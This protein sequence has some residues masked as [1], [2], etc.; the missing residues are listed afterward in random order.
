MPSQSLGTLSLNI[1]ANVSQFNR[2][3]TQANSQLRTFSQNVKGMGR[4]AGLKGMR[5]QMGKTSKSWGSGMKSMQGVTGVAM[6]NIVAMIAQKGMQMIT[7]AFKFIIN[8]FKEYESA[9]TNAAAVSGVYGAAI[10]TVKESMS[11]F[12]KTLS[13]KSIYTMNE[14]A[15]VMYD[16]SSAGYDITNLM[17]ED[18]IPVLNFA[19]ATQSTLKEATEMVLVALKQFDLG[20][21]ESTEVVDIWMALITNSFSTLQKL[22]AGMKYTGTIAGTLGQD[23]RTVSSAIA[24]L[25]DLGYEGGKAGQSLNMI[26]TKLISPTEKARK[27]LDSIGVTLEDINPETHSLVEILHTLKE[28]GFD[29]AIASEMFRAKTAAAAI[30]LV[31]NVDALSDYVNLTKELGGITEYVAEEQIDTLDGSLKQLQGA[32][33]EVGNSI[34]EDIAPAMKG[35][36][37]VITDH[38]K[39]ALEFLWKILVSIN[40]LLFLF[41]KALETF[42]AMKEV[43]ER[44]NAA[45][46]ALEKLKEVTE[47]GMTIM[48]EYSVAMDK[49]VD[50]A[51]QERDITEELS[52][53]RMEGLQD[54]QEYINLEMKLMEVRRE[55]Y[56]SETNLVSSGNEIVN[57][58]VEGNEQIAKAITWHNKLSNAEEG[59][60]DEKRGRIQLDEDLINKENELAEVGRISGTES[61]EYNKLMRE[62]GNI[63][64]DID[65]SQS[66]QIKY[67]DDINYYEEKYAEVLK[68]SNF[69]ERRA[70]EYAIELIETR[71]ELL[72]AQTA[73]DKELI[74]YNRLIDVS[75]NFEKLHEAAMK[76]VLEIQDKLLDVELKRY[77]LTDD[78][79]SQLDTMFDTLAE[80][81]MLTQDIIDSYTDK[82]KAEGQAMKSRAALSKFL[83]NL[84]NEDRDA[85]TDWI[86]AYIDSGGDM[87]KANSI[88]GKS[89]L[90]LS[91]VTNNN[92]DII[93]NYGNAQILANETAETLANTI[94]PFTGDLVENGIATN[95]AATAW[96]KYTTGLND[97]QQYIQKTIEII[98]DMNDAITRTINLWAIRWQALDLPISDFPDFDYEDALKEGEVWKNKFTDEIINMDKVV[99]DD[100]VGPLAEGF[101]RVSELGDEWE[102][103][104]YAEAGLEAMKQSVWET[105]RE[106]GYFADKSA[107]AA[108][109]WE[110]YI[111]FMAS[112]GVSTMDAMS[113]KGM[114]A[115]LSILNIAG[116]VGNVDEALNSLGID[117]RTLMSISD[118]AVSS[119]GDD[120]DTTKLKIQ[121]ADDAIIKLHEDLK[122]L[123]DDEYIITIQQ[124]VVEAEKQD[125]RNDVAESGII[126]YVHDIN[127]KWTGDPNKASIMG[128]LDFITPWEGLVP[129]VPGMQ[130]GGIFNSPTPGIF[131]EKGA[132]ALVPLEGTNKNRGLG[133][134]KS[135][136]PRYYPEL[137]YQTG[138]VFGN[139][140]TTPQADVTKS[141]NLYGDI[142]ITG[143]QN[144]REMVDAFLREMEIRSRG[145]I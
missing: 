36:A 47:S 96:T 15:A 91:G 65:K 71:G 48:E 107:D 80:D 121:G 19:A 11:E 72:D 35:L 6:G 34:G 54:T 39:P 108:I 68:N 98:D 119:L 102:F 88:I 51:K 110:G 104:D 136:I 140:I 79:I 114:T 32:L 30:A 105:N 26:F 145:R 117:F 55:R 143:V 128:F 58:L 127:R 73:Y 137:M 132:E 23:I 3:L 92:I 29:A 78:R 66:D 31:D 101:Y 18:L 129:F 10:D 14:V 50:V 135:I 1:K 42:G 77:K 139:A 141:V 20:I 44:V 120:F 90:E 53:L 38:L 33:T 5:T 87:G 113:S 16:I 74:H 112:Q 21:E 49:Y 124:S 40:P 123:A 85:V 25:A 24:V 86:E 111:T 61:D 45:A 75:I 62:R 125:A 41:T 64:D 94:V 56:D 67:L 63:L 81:G 115:A 89:L 95:D 97:D 57:T 43:T 60:N 46:D 28:A 82:E 69:A 134:I 9:I 109:V 4:G 27:A 142:N 126:K 118:T 130:R 116:N 83:G 84:T 70:I 106:T 122:K 131:G 7:Q 12:A 2:G 103:I 52:E 59:L 93:T 17:E 76:P 99:A 13:R 8:T 22:Q 138:G 37:A 133:I 144:S 100:I